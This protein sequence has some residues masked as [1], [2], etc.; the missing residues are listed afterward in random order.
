MKEDKNLFYNN[1]QK[2]YQSAERYSTTCFYLYDN[3]SFLEF[4]KTFSS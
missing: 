3:L 4:F 2:I 1:Y